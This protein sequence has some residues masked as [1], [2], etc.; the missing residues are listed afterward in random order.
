MGVINRSDLYYKDYSWTILK[1]D[2]PKISGEPDR[3]LLSR[4]EGYEILYFVNK[5]SEISNF[6]NK[7]SAIKIEKMIREEVPHNIHSQENIKTWI[8][9]NWNKSKF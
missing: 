1:N 6:K 4:K 7:S 9:D 2:D 5:L 8:N 3:S